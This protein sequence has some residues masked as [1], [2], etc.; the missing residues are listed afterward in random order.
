[1]LG[2][3]SHSL[4][5]EFRV[6]TMESHRI[7]FAIP[8][9]MHTISLTPPTCRSSKRVGSE[10][11]VPVRKATDGNS[12]RGRVWG[13]GQVLAIIVAIGAMLLPWT[14]SYAA[15][16]PLVRV[17]YRIPPV[18]APTPS[19]IEQTVEGRVRVQAQDGGL[20]LEDRQGTLWPITASQ[21]PVIE[22]LDVPFTALTVDEWAISL[23]AEFGEGFEVVRTPHYLI[24][25]NA[26]RGY[27]EWCG[28]LFE[29][30][31]IGFQKFWKD[32]LPGLEAP[33]RPLVAIAFAT[34][35]EYQDFQVTDA[36]GVVGAAQGYF[37]SRTNRMVLFDQ[38]TSGSNPNRTATDIQKQALRNLG[39][40]AT[41][42]HEAV[43][44]LS[45][46]IGL[47][48]RYA[49]NP[50]WFSEG[51]AMYF[52]T[53]DLEARAGWRTIGQINPV[54]LDR[55]RTLAKQRPPEIR[56]LLATDDRFRDPQLAVDAYAEAWALHFFLLR[57]QKEKYDNYLHQLTT[58]PPM[59][60]DTPD[61]RVADFEAAFGPLAAVEKEQAKFMARQRGGR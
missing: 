56:S 39:N 46:N 25:T 43:H 18:A 20:L 24:C 54:R 45:F 36:G 59:K 38:A 27:G 21:S 47:Q 26:G 60:W 14:S 58:K 2:Q 35:Q 17:R 57:T 42:I 4:G 61:Q 41:V 5:L 48:T 12:G 1:M 10:G 33:D 29:R 31:H 9:S 13:A 19:P 32:R 15:E 16:E 11:I 50:V 52:E 7:L 51:L 22:T 37:S 40:I 49:D 30:L 53:P 8:T 44:Q 6:L 28:Q 3:R 34:Q 55:Y 23:K